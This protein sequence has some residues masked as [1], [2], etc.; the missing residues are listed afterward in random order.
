MDWYVSTCA[1]VF[2]P[3]KD[4]QRRITGTRSEPLVH[5]CA[6][7]I[8]AVVVPLCCDV[9]L[10]RQY[11]SCTWHDLVVASVWN[12][13]GGWSSNHAQQLA[14]LSSAANCGWSAPDLAASSS[15]VN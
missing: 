10:L 9:D 2:L 8:T 3:G 5:I 6:T 14:T 4:L 12:C 13:C 15:G 11:G 1:E 7:E